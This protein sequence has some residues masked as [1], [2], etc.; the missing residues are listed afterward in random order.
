MNNLFCSE[1]GYQTPKL[2]T[3]A[4][5]FKEDKIL[6]VKEMN[7]TWALPGG[8]VDVGDKNTEEQI[9]MC[10]EAYRSKNWKT[11]LD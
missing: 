10:F 3:R 6:L 2:D 8:W 11:Y 5:I 7:G 4:A 9:A 1:A